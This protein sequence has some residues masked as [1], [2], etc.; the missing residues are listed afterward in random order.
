MRKYAAI[1][2]ISIKN[3]LVYRAN[4][5]GRI[6]FYIV[7]IFV[8]FS[9][10][11]MIYS[12]NEI[13]GYSLTQMIWYVCMTE[14]VIFCSGSGIF[15]SM[16]H[17][18]KSGAVAYQLLRPWNYTFM[19][20]SGTLGNMT[21][22][23]TI[24]TFMAVILGMIFVGP[25]QGFNPIAL[26]FIIISFLLSITMNFFIYMSLGLL[27]F[28]FEESSPFY[29]IYQKLLFVFGML[30]PIEFLPLWAQGILKYLP[31][32]LI[33]WAPAK[34]VVDFSMEHALH[35]IPLQAVWCCGAI[36]LALFVFSRGVRK[37]NVHGG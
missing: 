2:G 26:P 16:S 37:V 22:S 17:E 1:A 13:A 29:F 10:W 24:F 15:G 5:T 8:F 33:T 35:A 34:M 32:S 18:V 12:G 30:L 21:F 27:A 23:A 11:T 9:L 3:A 4:M 36:L 20:F 7:F 14:L 19:Q 6:I 25:I 31:F 28:Y